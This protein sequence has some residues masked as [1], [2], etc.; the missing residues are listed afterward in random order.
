MELF[1]RSFKLYV[2]SGARKKTEAEIDILRYGQAGCPDFEAKL[3]NF[4][5]EH[6]LRKII[7]FYFFHSIHLNHFFFG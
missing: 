5:I 1:K 4:I 3:H 6:Y 2:E 7:L